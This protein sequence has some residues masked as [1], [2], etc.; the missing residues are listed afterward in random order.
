MLLTI[1]IGRFAALIYASDSKTVT[2]RLWD[3]T[4]KELEFAGPLRILEGLK[5]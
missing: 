4:M 5:Q 1:L 3:E 2:E